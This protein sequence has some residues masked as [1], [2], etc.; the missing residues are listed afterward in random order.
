MGYIDI[1]RKRMNFSPDNPLDTLI[2]GNVANI[3][4]KNVYTGDTFVGVIVEDDSDSM[5]DEKIL[6]LYPGD[7]H[8]GDVIEW[9]EKKWILFQE[10]LNTLNQYNKFFI[11][12]CLGDIKFLLNGK[13][14]GTHPIA[15]LK[16]RAG[17]STT[18]VGARYYHA[19]GNS[20]LSAI[21]NKNEETVSLK[22]DDE[23][24]INKNIWEIESLNN[25]ESDSVIVLGLR[26]GKISN[27]DDVISGVANTI[28][29]LNSP[30]VTDGTYEYTIE[31]EPTISVESYKTYVVKKIDSF[32]NEI[33]LDTVLYSTT[34]DLV[35]LIPEGNDVKIV[36]GEEAG[37]FILNVAVDGQE[38]DVNIEILSFW[39]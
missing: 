20:F 11:I 12:E 33:P 15:F 6:Y 17:A 10:E 29:N 35:T 7:M 38:I 36:A 9:K 2:K 21:V 19:I 14:S 8:E 3:E 39:G 1:V 34:S 4:V 25:Y 28:N 13:E 5:T 22:R 24:I 18:K 23:L 37:T 31:G 16:S 30:I 32:G 26:E 27:S